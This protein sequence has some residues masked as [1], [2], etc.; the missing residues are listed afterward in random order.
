MYSSRGDPAT[1]EVWREKGYPG[2]LP[3]EKVDQ[4]SFQGRYITKLASPNLQNI[5]TVAFE[6]ASVPDI[7]LAV[8]L[9]LRLPELATRL[10][11]AGLSAAECIVEVPKAPVYEDRLPA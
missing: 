1:V 9:E 5:P 3:I 8:G 11:E 2:F 4:A 10:R 6:S 7:A